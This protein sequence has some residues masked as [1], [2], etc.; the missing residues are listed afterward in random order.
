[1]LPALPYDYNALEPVIDATTMMLHHDRHHAA[2]VTELNTLLANTPNLLILPPETLV[3]NLN[4]VPRA[5]RLRVRNNAGGHLNH[6]WFWQMMRPPSSVA[7]DNAP[8]G[9][10]ADAINRSFGSFEA[11]KTAFEIAVAGW[12]SSPRPTRTTR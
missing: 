10:L 8:T 1:V 3:R 5:I 2:Y 12:A 7:G 9:A 11:F 6:T 4:R